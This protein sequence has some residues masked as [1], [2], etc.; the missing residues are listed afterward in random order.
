MDRS[1]GSPSSDLYL[2]RRIQM[3]GSFARDEVKPSFLKDSEP[4]KALKAL[5]EYAE[6]EAKRKIEWYRQKKTWKSQLSWGL[7]LVAIVL[8]ALGVLVPIIKA[9]FPTFTVQYR[10]TFDLGQAGYLL[11]AIA[12]GCFGLDRYFG[13]SWVRYVTTAMAIEKSLNEYRME[14]TRVTARNTGIPF[15]AEVIDGLIRLTK[16]FVLSTLTQV[17]HETRLWATEFKSSLADLDRGISPSVE[18][19]Q[20]ELREEADVLQNGALSLKVTNGPE[21][22]HGFSVSVDDKVVEESVLENKCEILSLAPGLHKLRVDGTIEKETAFASEIV[23]V[24]PGL[25]HRL[26]LTLEKA[27]HATPPAKGRKFVSKVQSSYDSPD[28]GNQALGLP[29]SSNGKNKQQPW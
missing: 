2:M 1:T 5:Y 15:R 29:A 21:T 13:Y 20:K 26:N 6:S 17:E 7:R 8:F 23:R 19:I 18:M 16:E 24:Q 22:D 12:A 9:A 11:I 14:W 3:S 27:K 4:E 25:V 28:D 10:S